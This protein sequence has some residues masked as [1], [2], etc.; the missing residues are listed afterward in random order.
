MDCGRCQML[1]D[2]CRRGLLA[3]DVEAEV[4]QHL[5]ECATCREYLADAEAIAELLREHAHVD[6]PT[7]EYF[8]G[9]GSAWPNAFAM[10]TL[11]ASMPGRPSCPLA[12]PA[13]GPPRGR[14][15]WPGRTG[16]GI[17]RCCLDVHAKRQDLGAG[18]GSSRKAV[19]IVGDRVE[20]AAE[21]E[22]QQA[23]W[24]KPSLA[25]RRRWQ[26]DR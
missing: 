5:V 12:C 25:K 21:P 13:D 24:R 19:A 8:S 2:D 22:S 6:M 3:A 17:H 14:R 4:R 7:E 1:L 16:A 11:R 10:P 18:G 23:P 9:C 20:P 26:T 15:C